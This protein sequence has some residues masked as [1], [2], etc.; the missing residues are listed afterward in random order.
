[1]DERQACTVDGV[2]RGVCGR[3]WASVGTAVRVGSGA[4]YGL[5]GRPSTPEH[6]PAKASH[7]RVQ[8]SML[9]L[10]VRGWDE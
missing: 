7:E 1:M 10:S 5:C 4:P 6:R 3:V 9:R 2:R 8:T